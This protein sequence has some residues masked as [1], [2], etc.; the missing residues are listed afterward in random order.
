M[1]VTLWSKGRGS[2]LLVPKNICEPLVYGLKL[3]LAK[4]PILATH[5]GLDRFGA[6]TLDAPFGIMMIA[7]SML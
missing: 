5:D 7:R 3:A 6:G 1:A 4:P 2:E